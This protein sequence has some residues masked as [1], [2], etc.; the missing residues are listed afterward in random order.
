MKFASVDL[1]L[2]GA[3]AEERRASLSLP[4]RV[5]VLEDLVPPEQRESLVPPERRR[6]SLYH[7]ACEVNELPADVIEE[8]FRKAE[9]TRGVNTT[10]SSKSSRPGEAPHALLDDKRLKMIGILL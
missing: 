9:N 7:V 6:L 4:R 8:Y 5:S 10:P 1:P 2:H 3:A